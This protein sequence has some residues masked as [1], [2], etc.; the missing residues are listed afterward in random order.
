MVFS[1][2]LILHWIKLRLAR[3]NFALQKKQQEIAEKESK[4]SQ[5]GLQT[6]IKV[7]QNRL[8]ATQNSN[9]CLVSM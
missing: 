5:E 1:K 6:Q 9:K 4:E 8:A 3:H 2:L 7:L